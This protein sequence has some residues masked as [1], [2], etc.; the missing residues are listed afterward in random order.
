MCW[1]DVDLQGEVWSQAG[2]QTKNGEAHRFPLPELA[3]DILKR[4]RAAAG[5]PATGLV[6]PSPRSG[7]PID[8]FGKAKRA[9]DEA[10]TVKLDWRV[11]DHRRSFVTALGEAGV[12]EAVLD[13]LL[14]HKQA[15][16]R[17]GVLGVYQ[18][19]QRWP[20][21]VAAMARW[22]GMLAEAFAHGGE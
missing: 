10:L 16:T 7:R 5:S 13:A 8:T 11:H 22:D 4:R 19:A 1:E 14:N 15:S 2:T 6:F 21:Q 18:R 17:G 3:L 12:H 9:V 20:E